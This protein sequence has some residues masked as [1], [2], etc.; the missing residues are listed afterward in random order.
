MA[1][2]ILLPSHF[3]RPTLTSSVF[4]I[5]LPRR[6]LPETITS[7]LQKTDNS[8]YRFVGRLDEVDVTSAA[9]E[10]CPTC[11]VVFGQETHDDFL[12]PE[13]PGLRFTSTRGAHYQAHAALIKMGCC[14]GFVHRQC[15]ILCVN[16]ASVEPMMDSHIQTTCQ[17]C[18]A[19]LFDRKELVEHRVQ[20]RDTVDM[21]IYSNLPPMPTEPA[22]IAVKSSLLIT[23][24][25]VVFYA[26]LIGGNKWAS[27][28]IGRL[29]A[30]GMAFQ[31]ACLS[32]KVL[33]PSAIFGELRDAAGRTLEAEYQVQ[34]HEDV[35]LVVD[36]RLLDFVYETA[37][38]AV[39]MY[40]DVAL[41]N[42]N[43]Y[44]P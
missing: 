2:G 25:Q 27:Y 16:P 20:L 23:A 6:Y 17:L 7:Q 31:A 34:A 32:Q 14:G 35:W 22:V 39:V 37:A 30:S 44:L 9:G 1:Y 40:V 13:T 38:D 42:G 29:V 36:C 18:R 5:T 28:E 24:I 15:L 43:V 12:N 10:K 33:L 4:P 26:R 3:Q 41:G 8:V 21:I 11:H 19:P